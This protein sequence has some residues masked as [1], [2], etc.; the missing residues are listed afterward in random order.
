MKNS[1]QNQKTALFHLYHPLTKKRPV[2]LDQDSD[3]IE[4]RL[5]FLVKRA[6]VYSNWLAEKLQLQRSEKCT[7]KAPSSKPQQPNLVTGGT[8]RGY[9]LVGVE[10]LTSLYDNGLNGILADE[11]GLG[12]TLQTVAFL[13]HLHEM[14]T[15]GPFL[16]VAPLSTIS[17][18]LSEFNRFTPSLKVVLYH[19]SPEVR[20]QLRDDEM[21]NQQEFPIIITSYQICMND[22]KHL[23]VQ[24][25][26][27]STSNGNTLS[28]MR[29]TA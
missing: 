4:S 20:Q 13:A 26:L 23:Q 18:W 16:I 17:N 2:P 3:E 1:R 5:N 7:Q 28:S 14:G 6:G 24:F 22:R 19:G 8:L 15:T 9:Q 11:M 27:P 29:D 10:W 21:E 25:N 12:K